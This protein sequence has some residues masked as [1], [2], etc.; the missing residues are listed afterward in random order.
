MEKPANSNYEPELRRFPAGCI[1]CHSSPTRLC[2][3]ILAGLKPLAHFGQQFHSCIR[4]A[5]HSTATQERC[6]TVTALMDRGAGPRITPRVAACATQMAHSTSS[7]DQCLRNLPSPVADSKHV[8]CAQ[9]FAATPNT[10]STGATNHGTN[11]FPDR[12]LVFLNSQVGMSDIVPP[13]DITVK[14]RLVL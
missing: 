4:R 6:I 8:C 3:L 14:V 10:V 13:L 1:H 11:Y 9:S 7:K 5:A 2:G 12:N